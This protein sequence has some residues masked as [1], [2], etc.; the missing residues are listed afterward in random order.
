MSLSS[1]WSEFSDCRFRQRVRPILTEHG[2]A[3]QGSFG[4][5]PSIYRGCTFERVR[6]KG[7]GGFSMMN[8]RFEDCTF[9]NCRWEGHFAHAADLINCTFSG[10]MNGCV[11]FGHSGNPERGGR[12]NVIRGND[13]TQVVMTHNV[14][15]RN[16][17][18]VSDQL[19]PE[20]HRP[21]VDVP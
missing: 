3:A 2:F 4:N 10:R 11:W 12:R 7:L 18:P 5:G 21:R 16:G 6:F 13:F 9:V 8:A 20:G 15:W 19:W 14:G 1:A 17:F